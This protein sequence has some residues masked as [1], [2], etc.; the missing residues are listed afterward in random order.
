MVSQACNRRESVANTIENN[1]PVTAVSCIV[2]RTRIVARGSASWYISGNMA[3]A[4]VVRS[5]LWYFVFR[6]GWA[7]SIETCKRYT[8]FELLVRN[9]CTRYLTQMFFDTT[10]LSLNC[11]IILGFGAVQF[12]PQNLAY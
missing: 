6:G 8:V 10:S 2:T 12:G 11:S 7:Q 1:L 4:H 3:E 9:Y 5:L